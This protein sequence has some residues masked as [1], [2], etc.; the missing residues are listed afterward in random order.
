MACPLLCT[1]A[2]SEPRRIIPGSFWMVTRRCL[3]RRFFL[4]PDKD[5]T[6]AFLY[7][8]AVAAERTGVQVVMVSVLSNHHHCVVYDPEGRV[9]QFMQYLHG[10]VARV[11]NYQRGRYDAFWS[12]DAA[13][14]VEL[15]N[16]ADLVRLAVYAA[17]NPVK[18]N[19]VARV[20]DWPGLNGLDALVTGTP[21][22]ATR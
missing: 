11:V 16:R 19:L 12:A 2:V 3:E 5:T 10:F 6:N 22:V 1:A 21:L 13:C 8:L 14:L 17:G 15:G 9:C 18:D 20:A 7:V 4:R